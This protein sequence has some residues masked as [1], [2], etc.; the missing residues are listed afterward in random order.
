MLH[1]DGHCRET[2]QPSISATNQGLDGLDVLTDNSDEPP[3]FRDLLSR[4]RPVASRV[5]PQVIDLAIHSCDDVSYLH[6]LS[7]TV[8]R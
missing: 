1:S 3:L 8:G 7:S 5:P 2:F 4:A 6:P